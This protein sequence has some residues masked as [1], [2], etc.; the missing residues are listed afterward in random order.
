[1]S[2]NEQNEQDEQDDKRSN[3]QK[4]IDPLVINNMMKNVDS[5]KFI[6]NHLQYCGV[7][8]NIFN[9]DPIQHS[10]NAGLR[11]A[12]LILKRKIQEFEPRYYVK[13]IEENING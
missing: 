11:E 13:M 2:D 9:I 6:W 5:R 10:Y 1:M 8:E 12:G 3:E 4:D 7:F